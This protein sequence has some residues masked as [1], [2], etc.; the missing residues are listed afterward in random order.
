MWYQT[1]KVKDILVV[2]SVMVGLVSL[3]HR[4]HA[5][6]N[7]ST[8]DIRGIVTSITVADQGGRRVGTLGFIRVE[9]KLEPDT[10]F[11]KAVIRI[12]TDCKIQRACGNL[13]KADNFSSLKEGSKVEAAFIGPVAESY[14]VQA[15]A[16]SVIILDKEQPE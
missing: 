15:K 14:P 12:T 13:H 6:N 3:F 10:Q 4:S 5:A 8:V 9:G 2:A 1:T 7:N 11:D 16:Q